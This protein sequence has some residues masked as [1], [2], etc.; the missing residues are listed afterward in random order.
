MEG[1]QAWL[2]GKEKGGGVSGMVT[3]EGEGWR[4]V[5]HGYWSG[6]VTREGG[7]VSGLVT[8]N[9]GGGGGGGVSF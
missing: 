4:G 6:L 9:C 8:M 1:C 2:L 7:G 5:R 3:R